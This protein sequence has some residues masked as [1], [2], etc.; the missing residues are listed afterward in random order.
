MPLIQ[1]LRGYAKTVL[2]VAFRGSLMPDMLAYIGQA[3]YI[4]ALSVLDPALIRRLES[5]TRRRRDHDAQPR[6]TETEY[7][8]VYHP[9]SE[10]DWDSEQG[11][12]EEEYVEEV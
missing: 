11:Y 10:P 4:D 3:N 2:T 12:I 6:T 9:S 7:E 8:E 5:S 1:Q